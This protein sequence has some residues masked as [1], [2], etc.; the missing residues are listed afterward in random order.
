MKVRWVS[1][2]A[3]MTVCDQY[4]GGNVTL[5]RRHYPYQVVKEQLGTLMYVYRIT[6]IFI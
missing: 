5:F 2:Y 6:D 3:I 4:S 1:A